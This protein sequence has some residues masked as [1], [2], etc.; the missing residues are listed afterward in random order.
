MPGTVLFVASTWSHIVNFH[1][2][3]LRAFRQMG[4]TVHAACG[5]ERRDIPEAELCC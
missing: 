2:P 1:L 3:Y 5:G 4:W